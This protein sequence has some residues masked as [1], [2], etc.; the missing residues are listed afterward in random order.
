MTYT[1]GP[2]HVTQDGDGYPQIHPTHEPA[3][4]V[5]IA[6]ANIGMSPE[7]IAGNAR[8]I[9]AA[10]LL[11]GALHDIIT[12]CECAP[13]DGFGKVRQDPRLLYELFQKAKKAI[14]DATG[15]Q[16]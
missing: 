7:E 4:C 16:A 13:I 2:W 14:A 9:A 15:E 11:L 6:P 3:Y 12:Y 10:P 1:P 8:L 5:G